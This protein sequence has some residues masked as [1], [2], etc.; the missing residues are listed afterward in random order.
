MFFVKILAIIPFDNIAKKLFLDMEIVKWIT[1]GFPCLIFVGSLTLHNSL[2]QPEENN[3]LLYKWPEYNKYKI[4]T[5]IG[6]M[7][8][9]LPIFP[10]FVSVFWFNSFDEYDIGF[11]YILLLGISVI[12]IISLY[13]AK[14]EVK[15]I[16]QE[17]S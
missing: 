5:H 2:L 17:L 6:V 4:S 3:K 10:T 15:R 8:C 9:A 13:L 7:Y 14:F 1:L 11:Y 12:S 16:L